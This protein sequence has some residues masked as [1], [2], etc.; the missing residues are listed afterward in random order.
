MSDRKP[1][2]PRY[3]D[4]H[5]TTRVG[6]FLRSI[7]FKDVGGVIGS[8][9]TGDVKQAIEIIKGDETISEIDKE[10]ALTK[11]R[12]DSDEAKEVT[13]RWVSD[14]QTQSWLTRNVRPMVLAFMTSTLFIY[15]ILDSSIEGFKVD[16]EWISLLKGVLM[17]VYGGYFGMRSAEKIFKK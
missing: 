5:G 17:L 15:I 11:L 2:K 8:L 10:I 16:E 14:N 1:R 7:D 3:K 4:K 13:E 12:L 6:D 9:I